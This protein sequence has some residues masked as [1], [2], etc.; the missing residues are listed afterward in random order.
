MTHLSHPRWFHALWPI[1]LTT[2]A[3]TA[4]ISAQEGPVWW[5]NWRGPDGTSIAPSGNPPTEWSEDKNIRW[6]VPIPGLAS[7]SP[8]VWEDRIYLTTAIDTGQEGPP[9]ED[10]SGA[11]VRYG[12]TKAP[13]TVYE[14]VVLAVDRADGGT[15]WSTK[16][17]EAVPHEGGHRTATQASNS[18]VTDGEHIYAF[19]GSRGLYCLDAEGKVVWSKQFGQMRTFREFGEGSSP[20]LHGD[21]LVVLWD[22]ED[23]SFILALDKRTG[24]E[25]WRTEREEGTTWSGPLIVPVGDRHQ[26]VIPATNA[27]RSYDLETGKLVWSL[28]GMSTTAIPMPIHADGVVYLMSGFRSSNLQAVRL[29]GAKG[30]LAGSDNLLWS[31]TRNT[32]YV[33]NA[34]VYDDL[35]Y[36]L[37]LNSGILSCLDARSGEVHYEAQR[38]D[39]RSIYSSPVGVAGRIYLTSRSG[40]TKVF[41]VGTEYEELATNQLDDGFD[42]TAAIAGDELY[43][44]G[45]ANLYCIAEINIA[46][47]K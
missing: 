31:H 40:V 23:Q 47:K 22:H 16:V 9:R 39:M 43:L 28:S 5:S 32:S 38:L 44:R 35:V 13:G 27:S 7:S 20:A 46:E 12:S 18:P 26:V 2:L 41:A 24:E 36:F 29:E 34:L 37:R 21:T 11:F 17:A 6:K 45:F 42:A 33:P 30:D 15:L 8:V 3:G 19:F 10:T 25:L 14:F 1:V 4:R